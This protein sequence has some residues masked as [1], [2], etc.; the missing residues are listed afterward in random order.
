MER[1]LAFMAMLFVAI[2]CKKQEVIHE[3]SLYQEQY[4][5]QYHFS[6]PSQW[7]NDPN[8]MFFLNGEYHVYYQHH[9]DSNVW[10]PMHWGHAVSKDLV[11]WENLPIALYPD[12]IGTIFSGSAVVDAQNTAGLGEEGK[13]SVVAVYTY[14]NAGQEKAGR[15]DYQTQGM[16]FS[17]DQG[18][19]W[20]K[21]AQ[22][23]VLK[24]PG[25]RDFRDPKVSWYESGKHWV[26]TLAVLDRIQ[27]YSS[28]DLK[29]WTLTGEFGLGQGSHGGVWE[30]P[31]L[32]PIKVAGT[33]TEK[34]ILL[35]SIGSG[36][37]NGGSATQYFVGSFDGRTFINDN[38]PAT[39]L[40]IDG[41]KDN[42]A[43]VTWSNVGERRLFLGWM[44]NWQYA[45]VVPTYVWRSAMTLPRDLSLRM[46]QDGPR[47][48]SFPAPEVR[49]LRGDSLVFSTQQAG[50]QIESPTLSPLMEIEVA[51]SWDPKSVPNSLG[52]IF[53]NEKGESLI[54]GYKPIEGQL[55][56]DRTQSGAKDFSEA[57]PG[58]HLTEHKADSNRIQLHI[59]LDASSIEVF[60]NQGQSVMTELFFPTSP[61]SQFSYFAEG[62][63]VTLEKGVLWELSSIWKAKK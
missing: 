3:V 38:A 57:F 19:T 1:Y 7:M 5:P 45:Q 24:N 60:V 11:H 31:D 6:P 52:L 56:V 50:E 2:A 51:L 61:Y 25:I 12:S 41:G 9:P 58:I 10:G 33:N 32:F 22:N 27:F 63:S 42:Y 36:A 43:G 49:S 54:V 53:G 46:T 59:W 39:T 4:R 47:L 20:T 14:H 8:G 26:M 15:N 44:S 29:N 34:W 35:V 37:P 23:P 17:R 18:R 40:W 21:Y 62:G 13:P 30:C 48:F 16:A 55:Y 28:P